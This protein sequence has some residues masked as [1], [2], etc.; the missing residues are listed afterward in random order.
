MPNQKEAKARIR[1][2]KLLDEAGW[3]FFDNEKGKSNIQLEPNVKI[4]QKDIDSFGDDF[5]HTKSG[6]IDYLLLGSDHFPIAVLEAK[7]ENIHPLSA[8]EQARDYATSVH[9]RYI[10][11]S[12]GI[13]HYLW[14]TVEGN[15]TQITR[16]PAQQS[17]EEFRIYK[18][19]PQKLS[20]EKVSYDYIAQSQIP[21]FDTDPSYI[22]GG[23]VR[24]EYVTKNKLVLLRDYQLSAIHAIQTAAKQNKKRYL[25]EMATGTGKTLACAAIIKLFL[26]TGNAKRV[27]FLVDRIELELQAEKAFRDYLGKDYQSVVFKRNKETWNKAQIVVTTVQSLLVN[28][29]YREEFSPTD[30]E[31]VISDEAHRS[32]NGDARAVFEYFVGYRVG[33]TATPKDYL[34]SFDK[35]APD[36]QKE[37]ERRLLLSTY[38][39]FGCESGEPTYRFSLL[40]GVPKYLVSPIVVDARTEITTQ[41]LSDKG[42]AVHKT[43]EEGTELEGVFDDKDYER[44]LFNEETNRLFCREFIKQALTD[45]IS[46]EV[47]KSL[48]FAVSQNHAAKVVNILNEIAHELW[49]GKYDSDFAIQVTSNVPDA[50]RFTTNFTNNNLHGHTKWLEHYESSK[51]RVCVTV[52]MMTTGYDC[53]DLLNVVFM[54]PVYSPSDFVQMKGRGTRK[55]LFKYTDYA[56]DEEVKTV[57]KAN[58]KIIDFFAVCE[59][60]NEKYDYT[61]ALSLPK[62]V[63]G[64]ISKLPVITDY[65]IDKEKTSATGPVNLGENDKIVYVTN[66]DVGAPGMRVDQEMFK[67]FVD[68]QQNNEDLMKYDREDKSAAIQYLR[69]KVFNKPK[70]FMN[71]ERIAKF[72][73]IDR[74]LD[75]DEALDIIM[76]RT[77]VPK[78]KSELLDEKFDEV[79]TLN[80]LGERFSDNHILYRDARSLF[81]AYISSAEVQK[82]IDDKD[83][84]VLF[85]SSEFNFKELQTLQEASLVEPI[86]GYIRDYINIDKLRN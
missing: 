81:D 55:H 80:G 33:L 53:P 6:F 7:R 10:I 32:I 58:F 12:N 16:F 21:G 66:T 31:L 57:E 60:F 49:P 70:Y 45:P 63:T 2:N 19:N 9:A 84:N 50:Q 38:T 14:D 39:T 79:V 5:E 67:A 74:R 43:N 75:V 22:A 24:D 62:K 8:K 13:I 17:L 54:R 29:R 37:F 68:E 26:R 4:S 78:S 77:I 64:E 76:G 83:Y 46:G 18:P 48:V 36:S 42:L 44:K 52:A 20:E 11:L 28:N 35:S 3:R 82:A 30:F 25:L 40:D 65:E 72:F 69:E 1:I 15:P 85:N 86:V 59:Y 61:V 47:G 23:K 71:L 51:A 34:K 56:Q 73:K 41:L 27:L